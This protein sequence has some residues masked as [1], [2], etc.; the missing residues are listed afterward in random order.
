VRITFD[1]FVDVTLSSAFARLNN[2][3]YGVGVGSVGA[4]STLTSDA[5]G[6]QSANDTTVEFEYTFAPGTVLEGS[7]GTLINLTGSFN[8]TSV[9]LQSNVSGISI[10]DLN[11]TLPWH[12]YISPVGFETIMIN[13]YVPHEPIIQAVL[14]FTVTI[15]E[16]NPNGQ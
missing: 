5:F 4:L 3:T 2:Q 14:N 1:P 6:P 12:V 8:V 13:V 9:S 10:I 7:N 16:W 11:R 15:E